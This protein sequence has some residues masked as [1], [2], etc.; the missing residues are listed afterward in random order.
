M[1]L[2]AVLNICSH[3][4]RTRS[5]RGGWEET[6]FLEGAGEAVRVLSVIFVLSV[7][8]MIDYDF[9]PVVMVKN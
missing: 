4:G 2:G 8:I 1:F 9:R 5:G 3:V 6:D 7:K